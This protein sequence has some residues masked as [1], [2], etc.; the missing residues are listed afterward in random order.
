MSDPDTGKQPHRFDVDVTA[1]N[2]F[3][4]VRTRLAV[5]RTLMAYMR[6]AV[7]LIG[8]G[9]AIVQFFERLRDMPGA[10]PALYPDAAWYLG[11]ALIFCGVMAMV[12]SIREFHWILRYLWSENFA[13][14]AGMTAEGRPTPLY[15]VAAAIVIIGTFAFFAVL[16]RVV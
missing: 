5:E 12:I 16:L 8:F 6:T 1:N 15:A 13:A 4:W 7:S 2:H 10:A 14:I 11:L 3:A 9:F